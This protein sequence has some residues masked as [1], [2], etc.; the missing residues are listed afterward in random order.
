YLAACDH[1]VLA[2]ARCKFVVYLL[3]LGGVSDQ[4]HPSGRIAKV[5]EDQATVIAIYMNPASHA[6]FMADLVCG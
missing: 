4:L 6:D 5:D 1:N 3:V 2:L